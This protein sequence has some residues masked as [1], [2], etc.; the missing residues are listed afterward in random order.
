MIEI[1]LQLLQCVDNM[2]ALAN[3]N[4]FLIMLATKQMVYIRNERKGYAHQHYRL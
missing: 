1:T 3:Y 4:S 2:P